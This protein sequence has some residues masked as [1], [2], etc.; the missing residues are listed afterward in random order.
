MGSAVGSIRWC[1][2]FRLRSCPLSAQ[3]PGAVPA[4]LTLHARGSLDF[5]VGKMNLEEKPMA[6]NEKSCFPVEENSPFVPTCHV[7]FGHSFI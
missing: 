2:L 4:P 7:I 1:L 3:P 6:L 5:M